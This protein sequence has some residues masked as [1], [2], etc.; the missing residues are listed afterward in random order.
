MRKVIENEIYGDGVFWDKPLTIDYLCNHVYPKYSEL[1]RQIH[2]VDTRCR[3]KDAPNAHWRIQ[4]Y[5][6]LDY[7]I[8]WCDNGNNRLNDCCITINNN[9]VEIWSWVL[10]VSKK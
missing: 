10:P 6:D 8:K 2:H 5:V 1:L 4:G 7:F 3:Y 9:I